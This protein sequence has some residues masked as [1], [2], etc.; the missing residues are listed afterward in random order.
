[1]TGPQP[2][3]FPG[4]PERPRDPANE[5]LARAIACAMREETPFVSLPLHLFQPEGGEPFLRDGRMVI[6][7]SQVAAVNAA[8]TLAAEA[9]GIPVSTDA[10]GPSVVCSLT[11]PRGYVAVV[12]KWTGATDRGGYFRVDGAPLVSYWLSLGGRRTLDDSD[13]YG[14]RGG[15]RDPFEGVFVVGGGRMIAVQARSTDTAM[16][17]VV[18]GS[19]EGWLIATESQEERL[20]TQR[21]PCA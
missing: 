15:E 14:L 8:A 1:M 3:S 18:E 7:G 2:G 20:T 19:I 17:H 16:W 6:D 11:V 9:E 21:R 10:G 12:R 13:R 5:A 4:K